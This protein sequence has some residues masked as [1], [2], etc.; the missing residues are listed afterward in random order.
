MSVTITAGNKQGYVQLLWL[1]STYKTPN[2]NLLLKNTKKNM[3]YRT[4]ILLDLTI[5]PM[6]YFGHGLKTSW[7]ISDFVHLS[8]SLPTI[9]LV[10]WKKNFQEKILRNITWSPFIDFQRIP[11]F[12]C[13]MQK[14]LTW[15]TSKKLIKN[16]LFSFKCN[17]KQQKIE[18]NK[19]CQN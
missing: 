17:E 9:F 18:K 7:I 16:N 11:T 2:C 5:F 1:Q 14:F 3:K 10:S 13:N 12:I 6:T 8:S 19:T 15:F 4:N